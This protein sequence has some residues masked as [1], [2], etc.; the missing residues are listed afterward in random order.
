MAHL[1]SFSL[2]FCTDLPRKKVLKED[3]LR[4]SCG[5]GRY[6]APPPPTSVASFRSF[7]FFGARIVPVANREVAEV[8]TLPM[9]ERIFAQIKRA[10][11]RTRAAHARTQ[12][13]KG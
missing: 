3:I 12:Q 2:D 4:T 13:N 8:I 7:F 9:F 11:F 5:T 1:L 10:W 6:C